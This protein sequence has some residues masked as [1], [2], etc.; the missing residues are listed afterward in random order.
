VERLRKVAIAVLAVF[1]LTCRATERKPQSMGGQSREGEVR[2][3][4]PRNSLVDFREDKDAPK[5][6]DVGIAIALLPASK[7]LKFSVG[8]PIV[9]HGAY[10]ADLNLIRLCPAGMS[11]SVMMTLIR[12]DRPWGE[13]ARLITPQ[14]APSL[15]RVPKGTDDPTYR[16]VEQF[17]VDL[18][19]FFRL[20]K[21]PGKYSI[22]AAL[23]PHFSGRISFAIE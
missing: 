9:L 22:E 6:P 10:Q 23:G 11:G 3:I 19:K 7:P 21:E 20:P 5:P 15:D 18:V 17:R 4:E 13:T 2:M 14:M 12:T 1:C 16:E 8:Q